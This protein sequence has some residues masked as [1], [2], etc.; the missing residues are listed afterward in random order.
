M[1]IST[2]CANLCSN[3]CIFGHQVSLE[4]TAC[5][6]GDRVVTHHHTHQFTLKRYESS[7]AHIM[8]TKR[9]E[10]CD[11]VVWD[12]PSTHVFSAFIQAT[13][14]LFCLWIAVWTSRF[15]PIRNLLLR[16]KANKLNPQTRMTGCCLYA[17][18]FGVFM[19]AHRISQYLKRIKLQNICCADTPG[20]FVAALQL[21]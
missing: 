3:N 5:L 14:M 10:M 9:S 2:S 8:S 17:L 13:K 19:N 6:G 1:K 18:D 12:T 16:K 21:K 7:H 20:L 4:M 15:R 11:C